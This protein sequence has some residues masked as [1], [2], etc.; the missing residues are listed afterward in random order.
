MS[1][2]TEQ[3]PSKTTFIAAFREHPASVG[4]TYTE[5]FRVAAG[6]S[7]ELAAA[8][9]AAA[10]HAV[11]PAMCTKTASRKIDALHEKMHAGA[12]GGVES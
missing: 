3:T 4:E 9:V 7:R 6:F 1:S 10:L 8:A 11:C 2:T 5:H 12:R